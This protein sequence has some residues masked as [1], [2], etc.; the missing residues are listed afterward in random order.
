MP[1]VIWLIRGKLKS[2]NTVQV[3]LWD[4]GTIS[5]TVYIC[6]GIGDTYK[7]S[8]TVSTLER[9]YLIYYKETESHKSSSIPATT[10]TPRISYI[11]GAFLSN[12]I[13]AC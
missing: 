1:Q 6:S 10:G 7:E 8:I 3:F 11:V 12:V 4:N 9:F 5:L 13:R 2:S